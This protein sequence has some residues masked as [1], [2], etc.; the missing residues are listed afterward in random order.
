M[1]TDIHCGSLRDGLAQFLTPQVWKQAHQAWRPPQTPGRWTLQPLVWVLLGLTW[2]AGG[3]QEERFATAGASYIACH[4]HARRP[5]T[6]LTGFLAALSRL[7]LPVLR[8]L[9]AGVRQQLG[10][11][12]VEPLRLHGWV[13]LAC[14]G[15]RPECP[16]AEELQRRLGEAGKP[17]SAPTLYLTTLVLLPAALLWSWCLGKGTASEHDHLRRLLATLPPHALIVADAC[18]LGYDLFAAILGARAS[19]LVRLSSRAYLYTERDVPLERFREG[20]V[21]YW[22][23]AAQDAGRPPLRARL[24]RGR[25]QKADVWLLTDVLDRQRLSRRTAAQVYRWRWRNEGLFRVYKRMLG[26]LKLQSRTVRLV[27]REA[28]GSLLALQLLL[29]LAAQ[30]AARGRQVVVLMDSPR[31]VLLRLRGDY[32]ALLRGLGP[33][34]FARYRRQLEVVRGDAGVRHKGKAR[35]EWPRRKGHKPPKPPKLRVLSPALKAKLTKAL[36]VA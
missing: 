20:L 36:N 8:A 10:A 1:S 16:R 21:Y 29:A 5:G 35:Q 12:F 2:C 34:Q 9:A 17:G 18:F 4:Q 33:R 13:P 32:Q 31:R 14:D 19:F 30:A 15:T 22:P 28:E 6:T 3:S 7:P 23:R 25:G 11:R 27:H 26:K 24:L